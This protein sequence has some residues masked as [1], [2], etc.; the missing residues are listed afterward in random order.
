MS[1]VTCKSQDGETKRNPDLLV[2]RKRVRRDA[3]TERFLWL[4]LGLGLQIPAGWLILKAE[5][6]LPSLNREW[7]R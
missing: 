4:G 1:K 3:G 2:L 5:W 7:V 6:E